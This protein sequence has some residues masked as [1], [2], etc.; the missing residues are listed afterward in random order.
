[1]GKYWADILDDYLGSGQTT[2]SV[3]PTS[4]SV[5]PPSGSS[6]GMIFHDTFEISTDSWTARGNVTL[7]RESGLAVEGGYSLAVT[8]RNDSWNGAYKELSTSD[9]TPGKAY[10]FSVYVMQR[11]AAS[12]DF[13]LTLQYSDGVETRYDSIATVTASK[14]EWAQLSNT[15][16]LIPE[17]ARDMQL[18]VETADSTNSFYFDEASAAP[19]GTSIVSNPTMPQGVLELPGDVNMDG[20]VDIDDVTKIITVRC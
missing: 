12:D 16:Y 18:V 14:A 20:V 15:S 1:M 3:T 5:T 19:G 6:S 8:G 7:A 17:G 4:P 2:P 10:S 9:F 13:K 11:A